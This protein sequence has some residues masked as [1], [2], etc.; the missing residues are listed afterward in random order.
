MDWATAY[1][2]SSITSPEERQA[3]IRFGSDDQAKIWLNGEKV[4]S[5]NENRSPDIDQNTVPVTLK[6]GENSILVKVSD[7]E[8]G[9]G[10]Y[11]RLTD[12][13]G[14]PMIDLTR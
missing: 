12:L 5:F 9:W 11:L 14:V 13:R 4:F 1:A 8:L 6:A 2:W 3:H 7:A 10:F